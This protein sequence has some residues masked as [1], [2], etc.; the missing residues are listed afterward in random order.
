MKYQPGDKIIVLL[1]EEEGT[2]LEIMNEKM[3]LIEVKGVKFPAYTDQIDFPYFKMF[4]EK[5]ISDKQK[6]FI[7]QVQKEKVK[8]KLKEGNGVL[9]TFIPV[10]NKDI[11]DDDVVEKLKVYLVNQNETGYNFTYNLMIGGAS[12]FELKNTIEPLSDFYLHDIKFEDLSDS[13]RFE[14]EFS[15]KEP[16]KKKAPYFETSLKL[17]AKQLFKKI[18]EIQLKN[19]PGFSY[20]LL[21][22]YPDRIEEEK[23]DVSRLGNAGFRLYDAAKI[24]QNLEPARS[25]VDLHIEKLTN[26]WKQLSNF[27]ILTMQLK[28]F[29]KYYELAIA[30]YQPTLTIIHGVG[31]G[32]LR[33]EIHELLRLK[34]EVSSFVNQYN[35][36][37]GYG[38]TEIYFDY[39]R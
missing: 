29:E 35:R 23:V 24:K 16:D 13:P 18:E 25:V 6:V 30:H 36:L 39:K 27:E 15:L 3:V 17:K 5:R 8:P 21:D 2:V 19:E 4:S 1:T 20:L 12:D 9:L 26:D 14:I 34:K 7:D 32:K 37:Y 33:D 31:L 22:E 10:F 11:F 38:A 28:V